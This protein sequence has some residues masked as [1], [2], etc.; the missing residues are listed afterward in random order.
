M[1][2]YVYTAVVAGACVFK[3]G[4]CSNVDCTIRRYSTGFGI[5]RMRFFAV[6][7]PVGA[8]REMFSLLGP[9]AK[10]EVYLTSSGTERKHNVL[11]DVEQQL[12]QR[13][14]QP[15]KYETYEGCGDIGAMFS[16]YED[17]VETPKKVDLTCGGCK[18][19]YSTAKHLR[20]HLR[21][22]RCKGAPILDCPT[23]FRSFN[24]LQAKYYHIRIK[25]CSAPPAPV[26]ATPVAAAPVNN[27]CVPEAAALRAQMEGLMQ[28]MQQL[29]RDNR[30]LLASRN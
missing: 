9:P 15:I 23:C 26:A 30:A 11:K 14:G 2:G 12:I 1:N 28:Q 19:V 5:F 3:A 21:K 10:G 27:I 22:G 29:Q 6:T 18:H 13:Y 17:A 25:K 16:K 24:N 7:D 4:R 20:R 8:E